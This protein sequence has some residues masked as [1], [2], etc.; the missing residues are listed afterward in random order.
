M[1]T[2]ER[3]H[4]KENDLS[5]ALSEAS[6]RLAQNQRTYGIAIGVVL[7]VLVA[8]GGYWAWQSRG[9]GRAQAILNDAVAIVQSPIEA[10]KPGNAG[11]P[12]Q[13]P[14]TYPSVGARAEAAL[15]KFNE[16]ASAYP[17]SKAG[18]SARYFAASALAMLGRHEEAITAYQDVVDRAGANDFYG[19]MAQLGVIEASTQAKQFDQAISKAQGL[20]NNTADDVIPRD[21]LLMELGR[22]YVAAGKKDEAKQTLDK[23]IAEF[24]DSVYVDEA[25]QLLTTLT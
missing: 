7:L 3:H 4:L 13:T 21:A 15:V 1:K 25:K 11:S 18:I 23:V 5:Y 10:A 17:T 6:A 20:V 24:P 19:R 12:T 14:G 8:G 22:V 16:V 2:S 9:E